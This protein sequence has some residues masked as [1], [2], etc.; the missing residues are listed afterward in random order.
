MP[1]STITMTENQIQSRINPLI[2]RN[3]ERYKQKGLNPINF[4]GKEIHRLNKIM[5]NSFTV[6]SQVG[7][8]E[9]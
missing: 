2:K 6:C 3:V 9:I 5:N 1:K 7:L 4:E 8:S